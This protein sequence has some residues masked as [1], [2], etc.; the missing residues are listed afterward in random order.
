[1][2]KKIYSEGVISRLSQ[3]LKYIVQ[4][5]GVGK[6]TVTSLEISSRTK[7]NSA[8]I[9]RDLIFFGLK[10]KR[11]VGFNIEEL[12]SS[13]NKILGYNDR[14]HIA[15]VGAGNLGKAIL[16]YK[17]LDKFGFKIEDVFDNDP[18]VIGRTISGRKVKDILEIKNVIQEKR[19]NVA[20]IAVPEDSA[21]KVTD[22]L[23]EAR[24]K[25]VINYT[26][27]PIKVP[28]YVDVQTTDPIEKLLHTLYYLS[29]TV[30][31]S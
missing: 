22:I 12:I 10:G 7:I 23:V 14:V 17:I 9:R 15:L 8:E 30:Y 11:G 18:D 13:F 27:V 25:V 24:I 28:K 2:E 20:I 1:M 26:S 4:L 3:Y 6:R 31:T 29:N 19:I 21:Q 16:N 5:K